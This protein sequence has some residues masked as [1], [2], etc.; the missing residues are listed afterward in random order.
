MALVI[1]VP[2]GGA[3]Y[4][5]DTRCEIVDMRDEHH[6]RVRVVEPFMNREFEVT[7]KSQVEILPDV[8]VSAG[9][10]RSGLASLAIE[11]PRSVKILREKLYVRDSQ[12]SH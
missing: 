7:D 1:G 6:F 5:G 10:V 12:D 2:E 8:W 11:A 3:F 4:V 9:D